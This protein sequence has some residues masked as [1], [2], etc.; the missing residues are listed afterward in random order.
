MA[1]PTAY[2]GSQTRGR[3]GAKA[4]S[5]HYSNAGSEPCLQPTPQFT[6]TLDPQPTERGH[7]LNPQHLMVPSRVSFHY[8]TMGTPQNP[9]FLKNG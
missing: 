9:Q 3:I 7:G 6:A 2:G 5:L 4:A 1:A 8:A